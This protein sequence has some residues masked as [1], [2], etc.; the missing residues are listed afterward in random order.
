MIG[1][2]DSFVSPPSKGIKDGVVKVVDASAGI[3]M[4][5]LFFLAMAR[6]EDKKS[7]EANSK[8]Q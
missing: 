6:I 8:P 2:V 1:V 5:I 4:I 3:D 7:L